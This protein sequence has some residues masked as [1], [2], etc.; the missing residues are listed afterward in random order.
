K[1]AM[2]DTGYDTSHPDLKGRVSQAQ[3][4]VP[5]QSVEDGNGHGTHVLST[6]GGTGASSEGG[7]EKGVAPGA[8]LIVGKVLSNEGSGA[9]SWIIGGMEWAVGQGA[10][11]VSMSLGST[12]ASDGTD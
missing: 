8:D 2:L 10:K 9:D 12:E 11:V 6:I 1:V 4:F 3:S 7:R 5:G